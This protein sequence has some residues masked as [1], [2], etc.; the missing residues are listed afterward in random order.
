MH[1]CCSSEKLPEEWPIKQRHHMLGKDIIA[2][3]KSNVNTCYRPPLEKFICARCLI[4]GM[5]PL[6]VIQ[7]VT[8]LHMNFSSIRICCWGIALHSSVSAAC[9]CTL[10]RCC[11]WWTCQPSMSQACSIRY[12]SGLKSGYASYFG[13]LW[14]GAVLLKRPQSKMLLR[15]W[16]KCR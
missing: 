12:I 4:R 5:P 16:D 11:L 14:V 13:T 9:S 8:H 3:K 6:D 7:A 2:G 15:K 10:H 1:K